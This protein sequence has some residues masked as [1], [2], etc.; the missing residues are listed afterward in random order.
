MNLEEHL[1]GF[2]VASPHRMGKQVMLEWLS[3]RSHTFS[4][5]GPQPLVTVRDAYDGALL[6]NHIST[7]VA[8]IA[9]VFPSKSPLSMGERAPTIDRDSLDKFRPVSSPKISKSIAHPASYFSRPSLI[10]AWRSAGGLRTVHSP[11]VPRSPCVSG[12]SCRQSGTLEPSNL[13][14]LLTN[15]VQQ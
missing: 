1:H 10:S 15:A 8:A 4:P 12:I 3:C 14:L 11:H 6:C 7:R 13:L 9:L 5:F 2:G